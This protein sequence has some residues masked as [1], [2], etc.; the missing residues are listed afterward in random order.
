LKRKI[1]QRTTLLTQA[2]PLQMFLPFIYDHK[3][4]ETLFE[5]VNPGKTKLLTN[6]M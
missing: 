3:A 6:S 5:E 2:K 1:I 4:N